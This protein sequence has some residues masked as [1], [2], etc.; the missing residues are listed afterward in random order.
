MLLVALTLALVAYTQPIPKLQAQVRMRPVAAWVDMSGHYVSM[1]TFNPYEEMRLSTIVPNNTSPVSVQ[2]VIN[3]KWDK[4][5]PWEANVTGYDYIIDLG[6]A[7]NPG[8]YSVYTVVTLSDGIKYASNNVRATI[9]GVY[10]FYDLHGLLTVT[11]GS[12]RIRGWNGREDLLLVGRREAAAE[13]VAYEF[14]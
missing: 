6:Q 14:G 5:L 10:V 9:T 2:A 12:E 3:G 13:V 11:G 4:M 7:F 1:I 8:S